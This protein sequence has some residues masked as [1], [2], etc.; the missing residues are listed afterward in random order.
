VLAS[1]EPLI[2]RGQAN[3]GFR[4]DFMAYVHAA[5]GELGAGRVNDADAAPALVATILGAV[6]ARHG[7]R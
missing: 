6:S 4:A 2:E 7:A 3:R 1:L 5:S